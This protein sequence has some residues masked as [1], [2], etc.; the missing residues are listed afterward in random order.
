MYILWFIII[1]YSP[2]DKY[3]YSIAF[4]CFCPT[5]LVKPQPLM[6]SATHILTACLQAAEGC[7]RKISD[8]AGITVNQYSPCS[9]GV[10]LL[11][12]WMFK[13]AA[14]SYPLQTSNTSLA[15]LPR[16]HCLSLHW[17][18]KLSDVYSSR[19]VIRTHIL[20]IKRKIRL[21]LRV[22][23]TLIPYT[24]CFY[25]WKEHLYFWIYDPGYYL[26]WPCG[27]LFLIIFFC[28]GLNF[29]TMK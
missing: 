14:P 21:K 13:Y 18:N 10:S 11:L 25:T 27:S 9:A 6:S 12:S 17:E 8:Q 22:K 19:N 3:C 7:W 20:L 29:S 24:F 26:V 23:D 16:P 4:L 1:I 28:K 2:P 5:H 15:A